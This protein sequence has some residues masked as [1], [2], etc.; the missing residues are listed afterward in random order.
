MNA[1]IS[2]DFHESEELLK[3]NT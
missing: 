2:E 1:L 3:L